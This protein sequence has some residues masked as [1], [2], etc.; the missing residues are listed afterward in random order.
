MHFEFAP[1]FPVTDAAC[2]LATGKPFAHWFQVIDSAGLASKRREAI[3]HIYNDTGRGKDVWWPT[4][5]WVEFERAR[6]IVQRDGR[7]EG[8][9]ICCTKGFKQTPAEIFVHLASEPALAKWVEGWSGALVEGTPFTCGPCKG[10]VG[11][12]R[13]GKDLRLQW[14]SPGFGVTDV[15][16]MFA[17][18][19][20]KTTLNVYHKRIATRDE[21]DGLRRAWGQALE[22]LKPLVG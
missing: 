3:Q 11:R 17:V 13:D 6:G 21:A 8:Y 14:Q 19:A 20:G 7:A 9:N 18:A 2:S 5:I 12:I 1:D 16:M 10:T 15:E 22:R 4:T